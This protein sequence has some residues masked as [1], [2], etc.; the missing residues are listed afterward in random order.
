MS[1]GRGIVFGN[2]AGLDGVF[3]HGLDF[4]GPWPFVGLDKMGS[5]LFCRVVLYLGTI[6]FKSGFRA[7]HVLDKVLVWVRVRVLHTFSMGHDGNP[8]WEDR[9]DGDDAQYNIKK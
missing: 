1:V 8:E 4:V 3:I 9:D 7:F 5:F 2:G 6:V